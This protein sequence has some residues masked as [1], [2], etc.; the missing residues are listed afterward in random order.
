[1]LQ[2]CSTF[3][4]YGALVWAPKGVTFDPKISIV[5]NYEKNYLRISEDN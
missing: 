1:V 5:E 4:F 2:K 3:L